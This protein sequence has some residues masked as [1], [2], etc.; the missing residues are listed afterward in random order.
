ML[1]VC[2]AHLVQLPQHN[3]GEVKGGE[4][5]PDGDGPLDPVHAQTFVESAYKPLL[6]HDLP[7]GAQDGAVGV[8]CD[9]RGLHAASYHVQRVRRRLADQT[10]TGPE[11]Q[12]FIRVRLGAPTLLYE[13]AEDGNRSK[14]RSATDTVPTPEAVPTCVDFLQR[15]VGEE[16]ETSVRHDTQD[17][18]GEASIQRLQ[19]LFSGY[20]HKH[21]QN[22][23]IP[24]RKYRKLNFAFCAMRY[25]TVVSQWAAQSVNPHISFGVTAILARTM[26]RG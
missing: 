14:L 6:S 18:G 22:V 21:M 8:A 26:S 3:L 12:T 23:A 7:H 19:T 17:G 25:L 20:P 2:V 16:A 4:A 9:S 1:L 5:D 24:V 11:S 15:L 10:R 13:R